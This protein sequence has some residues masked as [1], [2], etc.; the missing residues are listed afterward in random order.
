MPV[1]ATSR[2]HAFANGGYFQTNTKGKNCTGKLIEKCNENNLK[3]KWEIEKNVKTVI[4]NESKF[5]IM[6]LIKIN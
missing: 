4:I 5:L 6:L 1:S 2:D 3:H